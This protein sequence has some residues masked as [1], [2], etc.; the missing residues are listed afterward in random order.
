[1]YTYSILWFLTWPALILASYFLVKWA[2]KVIEMKN[3][4]VEEGIEGEN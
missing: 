4:G 1:M 3:S 2:L